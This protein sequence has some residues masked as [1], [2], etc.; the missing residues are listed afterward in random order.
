MH[1]LDYEGA[2]TERRVRREA[3]L[4]NEGQRERERDNKQ[5]KAISFPN[6][7]LLPSRGGGF[8][9]E[10]IKGSGDKGNWKGVPIN[11]DNLKIKK[12]KNSNGRENSWIVGKCLSREEKGRA[13]W[14]EKER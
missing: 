7:R 11:K 13:I 14:I 3:Q 8:L 1:I 6:F 2:T 10:I 5:R 12:T 9:G 4:D